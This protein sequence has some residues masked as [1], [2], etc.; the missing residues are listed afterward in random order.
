MKIISLTSTT[1]DELAEISRIASR[2]ITEIR[3][4][5]VDVKV[6]INV[7][8]ETELVFQANNKKAD[9]FDPLLEA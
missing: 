4:C 8:L 7:D 5:V 1:S 2:F 3:K 6:M 9:D